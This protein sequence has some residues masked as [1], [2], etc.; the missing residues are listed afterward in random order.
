MLRANL[1]NSII[2][3][4]NNDRRNITWIM[5]NFNRFYRNHSLI[6]APISIVKVSNIRDEH[7]EVSL[8]AMTQHIKLN[9]KY[10]TERTWY[11]NA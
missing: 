4:Q 9:A 5:W 6:M 7:D 3:P 2:C 11:I 10:I 8:N 1:K